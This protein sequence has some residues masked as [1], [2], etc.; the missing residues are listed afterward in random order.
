ME[1]PPPQYL[2]VTY[3]EP[4]IKAIESHFGKYKHV[5]RVV[6]VPDL[7]KM[8]GALGE[9]QFVKR[10]DGQPVIIN[11]DADV[12]HNKPQLG[13]ETLVHELLEWRFI[14]K[15]EKYTHSLSE[16]YTPMILSEVLQTSA[17]QRQT[18]SLL[19]TL[20]IRFPLLRRILL[21]K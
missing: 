11:I 5:P 13:I 10:T 8:Y 18:I 15:G 14:E 17:L 20:L 9:T 1:V 2:S 6:I 21:G 16:Q 12:W 3:Y 4:V 7:Y 19:D